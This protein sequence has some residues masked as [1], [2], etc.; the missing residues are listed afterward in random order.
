MRKIYAVGESLLD[1]VSKDSIVLTEKPGGSMLNASVSIAK[2]GML[3][4]LIS[5][6]GIDK[7]GESIQS[8]LASVGVDDSFIFK[9]SS[10]NTAI[11]RATLD[12]RNNATY[13]FEKKYPSERLKI[14]I[15]QFTSDDILLFGSIY[16]IENDI[17][18]VLSRII[19]AAQKSSTLIFYDPNIRKSNLNRV[20]EN[21]II[22]NFSSANIIRASN[23][24]I[25]NVFAVNN[26]DE[27]CLCIS[28]LKSKIFIYT[29]AE[30]GIHISTP[31]FKVFFET[32]IIEPISTIG[33]GDS[34]NAGLIHAFHVH[35]I[36]R[37]NILD[38][39]EN[40]WRKIIQHAIRFSTDVC[41]SYDNYISEEF[42]KK[43]LSEI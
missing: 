12:E 30:A 27:A 39:N 8:L 36:S 10:G 43:I 4:F 19:S 42:V 37:Q 25:K 21:K 26:F 41:M 11:A 31:N 6:I 18:I 32:P 34:F 23:E 5:E 28:E 9:F 7:E 22:R 15:P 3:T 13:T 29:C 33:A 2:L 35:N 38:V 24:D 17:E 20:N 14:N 1:I 16:S 40:I